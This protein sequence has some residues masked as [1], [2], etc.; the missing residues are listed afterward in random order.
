MYLEINGLSAVGKTTLSEKLIEKNN[1]IIVEEI[2]QDKKNKISDKN[3]V[4][5]D[6][7]RDTFLEKQVSLVMDYIE[8]VKKSKI[9]NI[10]KIGI[11]DTG[12]IE[13]LIYSKYYPIVKELDWNICNDFVQKISELNI[14]QSISDLIIYLDASN[15]NLKLRKKQDGS[16]SRKNHDENL[17]IGS[18]Q[19]YHLEQLKTEY[20]DRIYIINANQGKEKVFKNAQSIISEKF[21]LNSKAI[22][23]NSLIK[24]I[25][26]NS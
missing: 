26:L 6:I 16:R 11:I 15:T 24:E 9:K 12:I 1:G 18:Y 21:N 25:F 3:R 7:T 8:R 23:L 13:I 20:P 2:H 5:A 14:D 10:E 19:K 4:K 22:T 17:R